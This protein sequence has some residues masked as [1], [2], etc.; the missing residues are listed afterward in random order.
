LR[1]LTFYK[2]V[3][4]PLDNNEKWELGEIGKE[5]LQLIIDLCKSVEE[6]ELDPF[7]VDIDDIMAAVRDFFPEW[8]R[9]TFRWFVEVA[10]DAAH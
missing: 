3:I 7:I 1:I 8:E 9:Q 10:N 4:A 5:R 6:R 2:G